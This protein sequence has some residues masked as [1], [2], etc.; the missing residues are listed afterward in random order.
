MDE[1]LQVGSSIN[2][3]RTDGRVH[4]AIVAAIN[5]ETR[6]ATVE[7]YEQGETKGKEIDLHTIENL[8]PDIIILKPGEQY[9]KT[10]QPPTEFN[11]LQRNPT[12]QTLASMKT[13]SNGE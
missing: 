6:C 7:W 8:N 11:K 5:N 10:I 1:I 2:I 13:T 3:K 12:R 9:N 4:S